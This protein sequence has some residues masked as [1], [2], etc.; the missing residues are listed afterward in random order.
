MSITVY[1]FPLSGHSHRAELFLSLLGLEYKS[2]KMNL[3]EKEHKSEAFLKKNIFG[4]IPVL[5]D[6][7]T[8]VADSN[9]ILIYLASKYDESKRWLPTNPIELAEVQRFLSLAAGPIAFGPAK[10]RLVNV[11]GA[12]LD[13]PTLIQHSHQTLTILDKHLAEREWLVGNHPT[14]ADIANYTYIAHAPEGDISLNEYKNIT[15]WLK[16]IEELD[17]F[18]PMPATSVGLAKEDA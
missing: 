1:G 17:G 14:I 12:K 16:R 6:N 15:D 2:Y 9:A 4:Q 11:F 7:G 3:K 10:A 8:I 5:D 18:I 13:H